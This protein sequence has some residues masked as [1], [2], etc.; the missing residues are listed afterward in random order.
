MG[1]KSK[2]RA[3]K[4]GDSSASTPT[5]SVAEQ[6]SKEDEIYV[7]RLKT[8]LEDPSSYQPISLTGVVCANEDVN[9]CG[10]CSKEFPVGAP[11]ISQ[12]IRNMLLWIE[13]L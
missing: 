6:A 2:R 10:V 3:T 7:P 12:S 13:E 9:R 4:K 8:Y 1:K 5:I 11:A